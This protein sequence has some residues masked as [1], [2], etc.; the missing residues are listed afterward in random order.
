[1][2]NYFPSSLTDRIL[3]DFYDNIGN[4]LDVDDQTPAGQPKPYG[5]REN[6]DFR[7]MAEDIERQLDERKAKYE[8]IVW[9]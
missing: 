6:K 4:A 3:L 9:E 7:A 8:K 5:A 1:M 2:P